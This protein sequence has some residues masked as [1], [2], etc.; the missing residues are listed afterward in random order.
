[1][2]S[3]LTILALSA[4]LFSSAWAQSGGVS[5]LSVSDSV[6]IRI[7]GVP[8]DDIGAISSTYTLGEDG[9]ISL[10]YIGRIMARGLTPSELGLRIE[11]AYKTKEIFTGPTVTVSTGS[12]EKIG[13]LITVMGEVKAPVR[14]P[15]TDGMTI[16]DALAAAGGFTDWADKRRVRLVR[17]NQTTEHDFTKISENTAVNRPLQPD[18]RIIVIHR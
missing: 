18:D 10:A 9:G 12:E 4:A 15:F 14:T 11:H 5:K 7:S 6:M 2:K 3:I 13:R 17:G 8:T 1:M 16:M